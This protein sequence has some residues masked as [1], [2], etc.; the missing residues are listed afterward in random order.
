[1]V[2]LALAL[3]GQ[4]LPASAKQV[5]E[6]RLSPAKDSSVGGKAT[7]TFPNPD[8]SA[9]VQL[10]GLAPGATVRITLH[11]GSCANPSASFV[12]LP[13]V[14]ADSKGRATADSL[15]LLQGKEPVELKTIAD[16]QHSISVS[17]G[18]KVVSCGEVPKLTR[19]NSTPSK[20]QGGSGSPWAL[21]GLFLAL[22]ILVAA[23]VLIA[24]RLKKT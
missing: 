15:L 20:A 18:G 21:I 8:T 17:E 12:A 11:A 23:G 10:Q 6:A 2:L 24:K 16:G 7:F 4:A 5:V 14:T 13:D 9:H 19:A 22:V 1:M 3:V